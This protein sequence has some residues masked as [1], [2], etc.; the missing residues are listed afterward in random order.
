MYDRITV[1][2]VSNCGLVVTHAIV[3][4]FCGRAV[5]MSAYCF[6]CLNANSYFIRPWPARPGPRPGA[7]NQAFRPFQILSLPHHN[8]PLSNPYRFPK[9]PAERAASS[10][11]ARARIHPPRRC[12]RLP[13]PALRRRAGEVAL[14]PRPRRGAALPPRR[15]AVAPSRCRAVGTGRHRQLLRHIA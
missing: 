1:I 14:L 6:L 7:A 13:A 10:G 15:R 3:T 2:G 4:I 12:R 9:R 11:R 8:L 5:T